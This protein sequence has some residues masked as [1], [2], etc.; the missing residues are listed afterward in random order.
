M[1]KV[2]VQIVEDELI[3]AKVY[4]MY[5]SKEGYN[6]CCT[7]KDM[8]SALI[9]FEKENPDVIILDI[10]LAN[11]SNGIEIAKTIRKKSNVPIIFT[12]G[13]P[14]SNI[15]ELTKEIP[16]V[17]FLVKPVESFLLKKEIEYILNNK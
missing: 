5:L 6:V 7:C 14:A 1:N 15:H 17:T 9:C 13:N 3:I 4:A 16:H 11:G 2:K 8:N 12:S 10:Q